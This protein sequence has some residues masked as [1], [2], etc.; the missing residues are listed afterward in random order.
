[1][2]ST[3]RETIKWQHIHNSRKL[4]SNKKEWTSAKYNSINEK[5]LN[6]KENILHDS[7][8]MMLENRQN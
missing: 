6:T 8:Y 2:P 7:I 3:I 5:K 1:M 4:Y